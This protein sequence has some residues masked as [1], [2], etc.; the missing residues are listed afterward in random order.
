M[1]KEKGV[2]PQNMDNSFL[3]FNSYFYVLTEGR[4]SFHSF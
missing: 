4:F 3:F 1:L 2:I